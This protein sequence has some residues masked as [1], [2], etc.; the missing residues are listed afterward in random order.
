[1]S[2]AIPVPND[3]ARK[4]LRLLRMV[5]DALETQAAVCKLIGVDSSTMSR[6][7]SGK[8][9]APDYHVLLAAIKRTLTRRPDLAPVFVA[10]LVHD[11]LDLHGH[12]HPGVREEDCELSEGEDAA[13]ELTD[14]TDPT[15]ERAAVALLKQI[16]TEAAR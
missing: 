4:R 10:V 16:K 1:M 5:V 3:D 7:L 13:F 2:R 12:W 6:W 8:H 11:L 9:G 15:G 14:P